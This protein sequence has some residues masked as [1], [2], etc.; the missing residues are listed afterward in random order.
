MRLSLNNIYTFKIQ[1]NI[2]KGFD[3]KNE[4]IVL[5]ISWRGLSSI[6]SLLRKE[7]NEFYNTPAQMQDS[8]YM[9]HVAL[10]EL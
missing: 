7:F 5:T 4:M 10:K 3:L 8:I 9:Y 6:L 1:C 2:W